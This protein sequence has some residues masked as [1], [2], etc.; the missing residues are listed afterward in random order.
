MSKK[1]ATVK[2]EDF[3]RTVVA[4]REKFD[5]AEMA[6]KNLGM[7][8]LSFN[9]KLRT[10]KERYPNIFKDWKNYSTKGRKASEAEALAILASFESEGNKDA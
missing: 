9:S 1:R 7:T 3:L 8:V 4:E 6:A 10:M 2:L 5:S